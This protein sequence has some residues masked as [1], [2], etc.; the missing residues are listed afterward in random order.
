MPSEIS[1]GE[2]EALGTWRAL[3]H[4]EVVREGFLEEVI[5]EVS[6]KDMRTGQSIKY[7]GKKKSIEPA[8][9]DTM[10]KKPESLV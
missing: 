9:K 10:A 3:K 1:T 6:L 5:P 7:Y 8:Y 2:R 4:L